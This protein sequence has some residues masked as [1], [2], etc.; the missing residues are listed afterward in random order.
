MNALA[1]ASAEP[2]QWKPKSREPPWSSDSVST[3]TPG[4]AALEQDRRREPGKR[5]APEAS[6]FRKRG[7]P[8]CASQPERSAARGGIR[9]GARSCAA[10]SSGDRRW[11]ASAAA[12]STTSLLLYARRR[13]RSAPRQRGECVRCAIEIAKLSSDTRNQGC[14]SAL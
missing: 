14:W 10:K 11:S 1:G 2:G 5:M 4:D 12:R 6:A 13:C 3:A 7:V 9:P 8:R